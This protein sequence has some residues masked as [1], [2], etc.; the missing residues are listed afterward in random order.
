[1]TFR[2]M[3][4]SS[5]IAL[6]WTAGVAATALAQAAPSGPVG[7]ITGKVTEGG[8][9]PVAFANVIVVD[10]K[11][12]TMTDENGNF[13]I[14]GVPAGT[15]QVRVQQVGFEAIT[16]SVTVTAGAAAALE[17]S[18]GAQKV[19]KQLEE[20]EVRAEKRIDTK[21]S[22]TKQAI[23]AEKL[24]ELPVDNLREAV[25]TKA[26]VV[27]RGGELHFRGGR[28]GEVKFQFD[29]VEASDPLLGGGA[30]IAWL[31]VAGTDILSG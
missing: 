23:S 7:R 14:Q 18:F 17:F 19:T 15:H 9:T 29:G 3:L 30:N 10:T 27:A 26:G 21:S 16:K 20:I 1:M 11:Q 4:F 25:A 6:A 5:L 24:R 8:K 28:S 13:V 31:A 2:R 22:T 12:G